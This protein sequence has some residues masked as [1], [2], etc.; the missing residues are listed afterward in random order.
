VPQNQHQNNEYYGVIGQIEADLGFATL[1]AIPAYRHAHLDYYNV[2]SFAFA[3]NETDDQYS[4]EMRLTSKASGRFRWIVGGFG[5]ED[6]VHSATVTDNFNGSGTRPTFDQTTKS[7]AIFADGTF[8][9]VPGL[10]ALGGIRYT[11][12]KKTATGLQTNLAGTGGFIALN[13]DRKFTATNFR[14]GLQYDVTP[15]T[16]VYATYATG[17]HA[18]G[19]FFANLVNPGDTNTY[20]PERIKAITLGVKSKLLD[21]RLTIDLEAFRWKL[22]DQQATLTTVDVFGNLYFKTLNAGNALNQGI[23]LDAQFR[24]V[25]NTMLGAK[26]SYLDAKFE[27]FAYV[28][29]IPVQP[30]FAC[31]ATGVAPVITVD[32]GGKRPPQAPEWS[33]NLNAEQTIE[34]GGGSNLVV[35]ATAHYQSTTLVGFNYLA[36]DYQAPV[37]TE[38]AQITFNPDGKRWSVGAFVTNLTDRTVKM[39]ASHN[40]NVQAFQL[41]PP[42]VI[43]ARAS[44]N[45]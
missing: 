20:N 9:I 41:R 3:N 21:N 2:L 35:G 45:F 33:I 8:D 6:K 29:A 37:W 14:A 38:D 17:Y 1:T 18:G 25:R 7:W 40:G 42:R 44:F 15:S 34:M 11:E 43:G 28:Q 26:I 19:F 30:Q 24:P 32:C 36:D 13:G 12:D 16:M 23:E 10:R 27:Q 4:L 31:T 22:T 39:N 5:L